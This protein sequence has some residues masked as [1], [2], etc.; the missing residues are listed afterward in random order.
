MK[1]KV[2]FITRYIPYPYHHNGNTIRVYHLSEQLSKKHDIYLFCTEE[3]NERIDS[4]NKLRIFKSIFT[5]KDF[6]PSNV[7]GRVFRKATM[8]IVDRLSRRR[9]LANIIKKNKITHL[10]SY[11]DDPLL[12]FNDVSSIYDLTDCR[13]LTFNRQAEDSNI[14][15]AKRNKLKKKIV[16]VQNRI[17]KNNDKILITTLH[18]KKSVN[19]YTEKMYENKICVIPNGISTVLIPFLDINTDE[20][21]KKQV[22]KAFAFW[23]N[24][25]Y[26][27]N[28]HAVLTFYHEVFV[29]HFTDSDY[30]WHIIGKDA[31]YEILFIAQKHKNIKLTG[32]V[33]NLYEYLI[34]IPVMINPMQEGAGI[35]NKV[36]EAMALGMGIVTTKVGIEGIPE[37]F[38]SNST[39]IAKTNTEWVDGI[40][41]LINNENDLGR[42]VTI[43]KDIV[44]KRYNWKLIA[45]KFEKH[46]LID[47]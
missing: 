24:L 27:P 43:N 13:V 16:N 26:N 2:L 34:K 29:K 46:C 9:I 11:I 12:Q 32:F 33:E 22:E 25:S 4:L 36:L 6:T 15:N 39:F 35:K 28:I 8:N 37:L 21:R 30:E 41:S 40:K 44:R 17:L 14:G 31:V 20:V 23:G 42:R 5:R 47:C 10:V 45:E 1:T 38:D 3:E 7:F 19:S 18:D